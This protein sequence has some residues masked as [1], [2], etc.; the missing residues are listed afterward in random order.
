MT[1]TLREE[2]LL[3]QVKEMLIE[4]CGDEEAVSDPDLDLFAAGF[5]DSLAGIE[6]LVAIEERFGVDIAPTAVERDQMDTVSKICARIA[7]RL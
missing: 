3:D 5:L 6:T 4:V 2:E 7:E 1:N